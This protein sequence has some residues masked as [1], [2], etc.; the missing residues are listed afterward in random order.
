MSKEMTYEINGKWDSEKTIS[1]IQAFRKKCLTF[2]DKAYTNIEENISDQ[3]PLAIE[4]D[5]GYFSFMIAVHDEPY[6]DCFMKANP[7]NCYLNISINGLSREP[8]DKLLTEQLDFII[9]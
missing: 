2:G 8:V 3:C 4:Y 1:L 7:K 6:Y 5:N 9:R